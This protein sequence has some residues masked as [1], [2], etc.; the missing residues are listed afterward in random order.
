L[1]LHHTLAYSCPQRYTVDAANFTT[2]NSSID[3]TVIQT[4]P[5][6]L[7]STCD[8]SLGATIITPIYEPNDATV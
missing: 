7:V 8:E 4:F 5:I 1:P 3:A 6:A 2:V